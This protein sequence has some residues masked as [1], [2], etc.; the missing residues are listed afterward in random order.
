[1]ATAMAD[2]HNAS[3]DG[4]AAGGVDPYDASTDEGD[5]VKGDEVDPYN[6]STDEGREI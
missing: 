4:E 2:P 1:M 5:E 3:T 6:A